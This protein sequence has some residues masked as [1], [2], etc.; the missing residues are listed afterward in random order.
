MQK[1]SHKINWIYTFFF[2]PK[3]G[4]EKFVRGEVRGEKIQNGKGIKSEGEI[5]RGGWEG[6]NL[7]VKQS[8]GEKVQG[9]TIQEG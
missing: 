7:Y 1:K 6:D 3:N 9:G 5:I 4:G 2:A 8:A